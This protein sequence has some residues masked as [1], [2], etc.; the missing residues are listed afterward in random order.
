[1]NHDEGLSFSAS[2]MYWQHKEVMI[3]SCAKSVMSDPSR[4]PIQV[5]EFAE[6]SCLNST[7]Q[8]FTSLGEVAVGDR[9]FEAEV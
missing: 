5:L 4:V 8:S 6:M 9:W 2:R 1:M 3:S 7:E